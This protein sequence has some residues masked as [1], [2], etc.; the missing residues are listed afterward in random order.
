MDIYLVYFRDEPVVFSEPRKPQFDF[1]SF[2]KSAP[3]LIDH[4]DGQTSDNQKLNLNPIG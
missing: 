3:G 1:M 2:V 4:C